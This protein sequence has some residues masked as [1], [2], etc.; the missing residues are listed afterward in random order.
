VLRKFRI[1]DVCVVL[2][3]FQCCVLLCTVVL[4]LYW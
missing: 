3:L 1:S 4:K 2:V